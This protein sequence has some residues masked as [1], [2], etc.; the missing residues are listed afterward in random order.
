MLPRCVLK[1]PIGVF[2][3]PEND[4]HW[5]QK[6]GKRYPLGFSCYRRRRIRIN[7]IACDRRIREPSIYIFDVFF[8][9]SNNIAR[10]Q[11]NIAQ[12]DILVHAGKSPVLLLGPHG[13]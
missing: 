8:V 4:T 1:Y 7:P 9:P 13:E 3:N 2:R 12:L 10:K 6:P 5:F 11:P